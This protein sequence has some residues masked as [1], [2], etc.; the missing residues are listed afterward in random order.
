[1]DSCQLIAPMAS[2][3]RTQYL[4]TIKHGPNNAAIH[5][6]HIR[7]YKTSYPSNDKKCITVEVA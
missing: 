2:F 6:Q 7:L 5:C 3:I 1:M 4:T